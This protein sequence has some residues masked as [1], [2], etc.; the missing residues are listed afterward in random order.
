MFPSVFRLVRLRW[1]AK[2]KR[3]FHEFSLVFIFSFLNEHTLKL[4]VHFSSFQAELNV[5]SGFFILVSSPAVLITSNFFALCPWVLSSRCAKVSSSYYNRELFMS[6][7]SKCGRKEQKVQRG[8]VSWKIIICYDKKIEKFSFFSLFTFRS[9]HSCCELVLIFVAAC[10]LLLLLFRTFSVYSIFNGKK[11]SAVLF[12]EFSKS[13]VVVE[14][15]RLK[16]HI[17]EK[18]NSKSNLDFFQSWAKWR[19]KNSVNPS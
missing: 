13:Y 2:R 10:L 16:F 18:E 4:F 6:I 17:Y 3:F 8:K 5:I 12:I 7:N 9:F 19:K 11:L 1:V 14:S 15:T